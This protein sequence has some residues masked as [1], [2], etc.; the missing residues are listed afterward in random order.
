M[1]EKGGNAN[2]S[3]V[4]GLVLFKS[5]T[6]QEKQ[7]LDEYELESVDQENKIKLRAQLV[8]FGA[9][10]RYSIVIANQ[11]PA[12]ITEIKIRIKFPDFLELYRISPPTIG[13]KSMDQEETDLTQISLELEE[14][15]GNSKKQINIYLHPKEL[16]KSGEI[17]TYVTYVNIQD[18]VRVLNSE[19]AELILKPVTL[20]PKIMPSHLINQFLQKEDVKKVIKS[21]GVAKIND[22]SFALYLNIMDQI[23]RSNHLQLIARDDD[24]QIVWYFGKELESGNDVL[25]IGQI[26]S[27][28]IEFIA[29][30]KIHQTLIAILTKL[31]NN[32][33]RRL[34]STGHVSSEHEVIGLECKY[35]GAIL[36][37]FPNKGESIECKNC[38]NEYIVW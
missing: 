36:P 28:K 5:K 9:S 2:N 37:R 34:M 16:N 18:Y 32:F 27:H 29:A 38:N 1:S 3:D 31:A 17:T 23:L 8:P 6:K 13:L 10:Y 7:A 30:S 35:C 11:S 12:E 14:L 19:S 33:T 24:K 4:H 22:K 15:L 20:G 21:M 26:V 25:V